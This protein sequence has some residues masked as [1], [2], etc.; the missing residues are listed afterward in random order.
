MKKIA[1][2]LLINLLLSG[3]IFSQ[4]QDSNS[5]LPSVDIKTLTGET[6]NTSKISNQHSS[7]SNQLYKH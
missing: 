3:I 4:L 6:F 7:F 1:L 5:S 2:V